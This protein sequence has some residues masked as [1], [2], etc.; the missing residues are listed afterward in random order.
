MDVQALANNHLQGK[1][2]E[3]HCVTTMDDTTQDLQNVCYK[4]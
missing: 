3:I 4:K 1:E 2:A